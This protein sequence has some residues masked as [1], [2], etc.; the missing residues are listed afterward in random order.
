MSPRVFDRFMVDI[1]IGAN[2]KLHRLTPAE[3]WCYVAGVLSVA[4]QAPIRGCLVIGDEDATPGDFAKR[5]HVTKAVATSTIDKL[6]C[7]GVIEPDDDL[8]CYRVHDWDEY[9]VAPRMDP[10]NAD[11]QRKWRE[12]RNAASVTL[13]NAEKNRYVTQGR[14]E[15]GREEPPLPP[16]SGG[17]RLVEQSP[18]LPPRPIGGRRREQ[19]AYRQALDAFADAHFP[20][21]DP[22]LVR[23]VIGAVGGARTADDLRPHIEKWSAA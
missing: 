5:A 10:T 20:D 22:E 3:R 21:I 13:R 16:A 18:F 1:H 7:L 19:E 15:K 4:A 12:R 2:L 17:P 9:Q 14:E 23:G 6:R 11:R 8:G